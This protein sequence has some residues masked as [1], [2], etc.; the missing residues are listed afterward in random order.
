MRNRLALLN[1]I[2]NWLFGQ[3]IGMLVGCYGIMII[4]IPCNLV[5]VPLGRKLIF[6]FVE[7]CRTP[8][9][10]FT[11]LLRNSNLP[12]S[13]FWKQFISLHRKYCLHNFLSLATHLLVGPFLIIKVRGRYEIPTCC[14]PMKIIINVT[15][16]PQIG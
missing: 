7:A 16:S 9:L 1:S 2:P 12:A 5:L 14:L 10:F 11:Y 8:F 15:R 13:Y 3:T 4:G 6:Y